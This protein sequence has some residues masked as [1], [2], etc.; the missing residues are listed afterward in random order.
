MIQRID[1]PR[2]V[3]L[4]CFRDTRFKQEGLS[5]QLVRPMRKGEAALNALLPAVLL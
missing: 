2:G 1:L 5:L 3:T 4:R